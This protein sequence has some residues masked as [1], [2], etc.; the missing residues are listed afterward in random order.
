MGV[1][2][3]S[4]YLNRAGKEGRLKAWKQQWAIIGP[5]ISTS[6]GLGENIAFTG[7]ASQETVSVG[8][9]QGVVKMSPMYHC[10]SQNVDASMRKHQ[11]FSPVA[12][13]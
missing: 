11:F 12:V 8:N 7:G 4:L 5:L 10:F 9:S 6:W 13:L 2:S 1:F 3:T